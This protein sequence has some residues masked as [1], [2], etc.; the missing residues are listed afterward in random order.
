MLG[1][2][3]KENMLLFSYETCRI[4]SKCSSP[5]IFSFIWQIPETREAHTIPIFIT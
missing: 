4:S 5:K 2:K 1:F 3:M